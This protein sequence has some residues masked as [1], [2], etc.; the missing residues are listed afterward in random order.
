MGGLGNVAEIR[1]VLLAVLRQ[2]VGIERAREADPWF[3]PDKQWMRRMLEET[4]GGWRV[5]RLE[6]EYRPTQ[7]TGDAPTGGV[8]GWL[9]LMGKQFFDVLDEGE[10]EAAL[11]EVLSVLKTVVESPGGGDWLGYVRLRAVVRKI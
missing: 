8:E 1:T 6:T 4:V 5:E 2:R 9:R 11:Q 3:F 10:R 7:V